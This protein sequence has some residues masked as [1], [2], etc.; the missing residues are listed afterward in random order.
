MTAKATAPV[1]SAG[2]VWVGPNTGLRLIA[3][4]SSQVR[5][6]PGGPVE[7]WTREG[8]E[9]CG[10]TLEARPVDQGQHPRSSG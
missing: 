10:Y 6:G 9:R 5:R 7:N 2:Q 4:G 8:L 3:I 1:L